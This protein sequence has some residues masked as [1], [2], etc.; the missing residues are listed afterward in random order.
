MEIVSLS[1]FYNHHQMPLSRS[2]QKI[3]HG[4]YTFI[5]T[6]PMDA[7]RCQMGYQEYTE[8]FLHQFEDCPEVCMERINR[9]DGVIFGS[10]PRKLIQE[11]LKAGKLVFQYSERIFK[12]SLRFMKYPPG[13]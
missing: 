1:N 6:T 5:A 11:R 8:P 7:E 2:L 12:K 4:N 13:R 10:T 9:A 3:L